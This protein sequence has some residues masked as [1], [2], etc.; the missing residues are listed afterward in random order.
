[1]MRNSVI[2]DPRPDF[3]TGMNFYVGYK[4]F[5]LSVS[6]T[7]AFGH[8]IMK[9]YRRWADR[10]EENFTLDAYDRWTGP[11]TSN[12]IPRL[13]YNPH[14]NRNYISDL[15]IEDADYVKIQN[16]TLGYDFARLLKGQQFSQIRL[17]MTAQ[18]FF[19]ITGYSGLDP[20]VGYGQTSWASGIDIGF[21]PSAKTLIFGL[22][23][24]F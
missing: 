1:M 10:P 12:R 4:G 15:Y 7:G 8:Q 19:T 21:Y 23:V 18:N 5:D 22:N 13:T 24:K 2:G 3:I 17:F 6:A 14:A 16:I 9:T 20:E 11:G